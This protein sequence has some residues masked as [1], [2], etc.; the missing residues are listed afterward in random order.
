MERE[1]GCLSL[2]PSCVTLGKSVLLLEPIH[3]LRGKW[4]VRMTP[5]PEDENK[6]AVT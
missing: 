3:S 5:T 6:G 4:G 2:G 1:E